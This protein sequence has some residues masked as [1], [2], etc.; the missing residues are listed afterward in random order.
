V[1]SVIPERRVEGVLILSPPN[2]LTGAG[3]AALKDRLD[4]LVREGNREILI[5]MG[6]VPF[7]DSTELGRLIR[8]HLSV[9]RAGGRIRLFNLSPRV[10]ALMRLSKLETFFELFDTEDQ[11]LAHIVQ[12]R[13]ERAG[14]TA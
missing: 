7:I 11:A 4:E 8:S 12:I 10:L 5:D 13:E 1:A 6:Q 14:T 2:A 3:E 9:R